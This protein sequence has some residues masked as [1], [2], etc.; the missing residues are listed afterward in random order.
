MTPVAAGSETA[1]RVTGRDAA[2]QRFLAWFKRRRW[3]PFAFQLE[4]WEA[5]LDG[6]SGLIHAPTGVGK[7]YAVSIPPLIEWLAESPPGGGESTS[8][9]LQVLWITPLRALANDSTESVL[10]PIRDMGLAWTAEIRTGDTSAAA[11]A[12]Q[13]ER[14]PSVLVTTPESLSLLLSYPGT[15]EKM[16]SLKSIV[17]DEWHELLGT[18]RGV[19][20]ELCLARLRNWFP[21]LRTWGLSATLGNLAEA[22][23]VLLGSASS[24]GRLI[25]GDL[26]KRVEVD[27]LLPRNVENFPW[28]GHL[29]LKLLPQVLACLERKKTTLLF[30]NTRSQTEI[31]FQALLQARPE[32]TEE[33]ALHHGSIS[34]EVRESVEQRLRAGT[35]RCVVCTS[36]LDLGVDFSPVQQVIQIGAPKGVARMLQRAGRSGHQPKAVSRIVC[37]PAHALELVEFAAVREAIAAGDLESRT[38]LE[39]PLDVLVQHLVTVALGTGFDENQLLA[40]VRTS[41][42]YRHLSDD[43]WRWCMDFVTRGGQA[44]LA[45]PQFSRVTRQSGLFTVPDPF[46]ARLHRMSVGTI[47]SDGAVAVRVVRGA[48][49]GT[50]EESFIGR[51]KP[52]DKFSFAGNSLELVRLRDMTAYVKRS[53][54]GGGIV[55]Q[56]MG[57]R[58]PL[59]SQLARMVRKKL[60]E[61]H[62]GNFG[63]PEMSAVQPVLKIQADWSRIPEPDELLIERLQMRDGI[64]HFI[65]PF[66]GR[67]VHEGLAALVAYRVS[68]LFPSSIAMTVNDYGFAL[69]C[70][71]SISLDET[72]WHE[73]FSTDNLLDDLLACLNSA[74]LARRQFREIARIAGLVFQGYPGSGKSTKQLQSSSGLFYEVFQRYDPKNLLLEQAR[75]EVMERQLEASRLGNTLAGLKAMKIVRCEIPRLTPLSFPLWASFV[76]ASVSSEKWS[77]RVQR[78]AAQLQAAVEKETDGAGSQHAGN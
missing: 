35:I 67:L 17:V 18:K 7:T 61:A 46:I 5:Y 53:K 10:A 33:L 29:G 1:A 65:F 39:N 3:T 48:M 47:T 12:R 43:E 45:Y 20:A 21:N 28:A 50:I 11:R 8:V 25:S 41:H 54:K 30:T 15:R 69:L 76:Q 23:A 66:A 57:G 70:A 32:W 19:Q 9:P 74:E 6:D 75:R 55:P 68:R 49:L 42:A 77:D 52:G 38:P 40:E 27:T 37:V 26:E 44:L 34:R 4:A 71:S 58:M 60:S 31:W 14:F 72:G 64:H 51:L 16:A 13:R 36:S 2:L 78:M 59:S 63:G 22:Q 56:W 62:H 73:V 24:A